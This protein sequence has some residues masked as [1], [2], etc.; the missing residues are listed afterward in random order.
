ML[1]ILLWCVG[2]WSPP[3]I[4]PSSYTW[5]VP[6]ITTDFLKFIIATRFISF[7][8]NAQYPSL[9]SCTALG[10]AWEEDPAHMHT[11]YKIH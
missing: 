7:W 11:D 3:H 6:P 10:E 9:F 4:K 8:T 5:E 2:D 1:S